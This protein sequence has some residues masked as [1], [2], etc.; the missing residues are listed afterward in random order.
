MKTDERCRICGKLPD[1]DTTVVVD[2]TP[3]IDQARRGR[4]VNGRE[5]LGNGCW[6]HLNMV[7]GE[8]RDK[9]P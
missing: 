6:C 7:E 5:Y 2:P 3:E 1:L 4:I 9:E 8:L